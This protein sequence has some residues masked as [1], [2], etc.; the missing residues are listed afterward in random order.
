MVSIRGD[1]RRPRVFLLLP[2]RPLPIR[3]LNQTT[4]KCQTLCSK[5]EMTIIGNSRLG[6]ETGTRPN[7]AT[8]TT[9]THRTGRLM[10]CSC[11]YKAKTKNTKR[12]GAQDTNLFITTTRTPGLLTH[13]WLLVETRSDPGRTRKRNNGN[14]L[15]ILPAIL[16]PP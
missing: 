12:E 2:H 1:R 9:T 8:A 6:S 3:Q 13:L 15:H 7:D 5:T 10:R 11:A 4:P 14:S 16:N